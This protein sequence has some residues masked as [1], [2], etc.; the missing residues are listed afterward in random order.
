MLGSY[1]WILFTIVGGIFSVVN[2]IETPAKQLIKSDNTDNKQSYTNDKLGVTI[3]NLNPISSRQSRNLVPPYQ[4]FTNTDVIQII[5]K[6]T[7]NSKNLPSTFGQFR[8]QEFNFPKS[9][10]APFTKIRRSDEDEIGTL[11]ASRMPVD[12]Y[13][14]D[15]KFYDYDYGEDEENDNYTLVASS[16]TVTSQATALSDGSYRKF[17]YK[18]IPIN[19]VVTNKRESKELSTVPKTEV[20]E[21]PTTSTEAQHEET[22]SDNVKFPDDSASQEEEVTPGR[23]SGIHFPTDERR[24]QKNLP[25]N[26]FVPSSYSE[27]NPNFGEAITN[28]QRPYNEDEEVNK[29]PANENERSAIR[30]YRD[31]F[32]PFAEAESINRPSR[33]E[34]PSSFRSNPFREEV[35]KFGDINGPITASNRPIQDYTDIKPSVGRSPFEPTGPGYFNNHQTDSFRP[36]RHYFPAKAYTEYGDFSPQAASSKY[37]QPNSWNNQRQPRVIFPPNQDTAGTGSVYANNENVVFR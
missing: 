18:V 37:Y 14:D 12:L 31:P 5:D 28:L 7:K 4:E 25:F 3:E 15:D 26:P 24:E 6:R 29:E 10:P 13:M 36:P 20:A 30:Y 33:V 16:G 23:R 2:A 8:L 19:L 9:T 1:K 17:E 22:S 34:F 32:P 35:T 27:D 21:V 11:P